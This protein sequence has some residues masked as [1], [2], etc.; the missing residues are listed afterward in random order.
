M[1]KCGVSSLTSS[2]QASP[3]AFHAD[4]G[5]AQIK[6]TVQ[7]DY[8]LKREFTI[9]YLPSWNIYVSMNS[10]GEFFLTEN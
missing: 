10:C 6:E 2:K 7:K 9:N 3:R 8:G 1:S 4:A 5:G